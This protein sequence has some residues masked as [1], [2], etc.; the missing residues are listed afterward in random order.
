M[1][2]AKKLGRRPLLMA[3]AAP[4]VAGG[5][6][7]QAFPSG[8][9]T[10]VVP[11]PPGASTDISTRIVAD[12]LTQ[13]WGQPVLIDNKGGAN[14]IIAAEAVMRAKPDGYTVLATSSMTHAGNPSLYEKLGYDA[15]KDFEPITRFSLVPMVVLVNK[16]LGVNSLTE[17]TA[18]LKAEPGKHAYGAGA[19]SAR[20]VSELYKMLIGSDALF[21]GY[22]NNQQAISD[23]QS[24]RLSFMIIDLVGAKGM[25]DNGYAKAIA[26]TQPT[27]VSALPDVPTTA[28]A[29][30]PALM[31]TTWSGFYAPRGTPRE[32]VLKLNRD[33][34]AAGTS[35]ETSAKLDALGG[36]RD[37]T[38]P[39]EFAAFTASELEAWRKVIRAADIHAE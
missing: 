7:A 5:A 37:F 19:V 6:Q 10:F 38:T 28:E 4:G 9:V 27:R 34:I 24:G 35:A 13:M 33:I 15:I 1:S 21:V 20:V 39:E 22:K 3:L 31:F 14:G 29:G 8:R 2:G 17:L 26:V 30:L 11:F 23:I 12:K 25:A 32:I 18:R 16:E 36:S